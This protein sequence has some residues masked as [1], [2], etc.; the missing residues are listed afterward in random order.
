MRSI[1]LF[2][3]VLLLVVLAG[4][5]IRITY[6]WLDWW[7]QSQLE[8]YVDLTREQQQFAKTAIDDFH[9]WHRYHALPEYAVFVSQ[10]R[11][12]LANTDSPITTIEVEG[13]LS[14][15]ALYW[16]KSLAMLVP[17]A[18]GLLRQLSQQ[19]LNEA[20]AVAIEEEEE[21]YQKWRNLDTDEKVERRKKRFSK[22]LKHWVGSLTPDQ[23]SL[24]TEW[25]IKKQDFSE[26][27]QE[28][29]QRWRGQL[30][31]VWNERGAPDAQ[32]QLRQLLLEPQTL[33]AEDYRQQVKQSRANAITLITQLLN[34]LT[35]KQRQRL[36]SKLGDYESGFLALA[37]LDSVTD[38]AVAL[39]LNPETK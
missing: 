32:T 35:D 22:Q 18:A 37:N 36:L 23:T 16:D 12:R 2:V 29:N 9:Q 31:R 4:C 17:P 13:W 24:L 5:S 38:A 26:L 28:E 19:Q 11:E 1:R 15:T 6:H 8:N 30:K 21:F 27:E 7:M 14:D 39:T 10:I 25:A 3:C 34:S 20:M 33:W